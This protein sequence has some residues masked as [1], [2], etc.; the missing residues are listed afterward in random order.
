[1]KN[2]IYI[3]FLLIRYIFFEKYIA[4]YVLLNELNHCSYPFIV[5]IV[6]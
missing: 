3:L 6:Y 2:V 4:F 1:M 5:D